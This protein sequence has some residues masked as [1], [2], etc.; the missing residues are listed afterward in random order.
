[1]VDKNRE[2]SLR[3]DKLTEALR[4]TLSS[5]ISSSEQWEGTAGLCRE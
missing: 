3:Q 2:A 1:M 4:A 5:W